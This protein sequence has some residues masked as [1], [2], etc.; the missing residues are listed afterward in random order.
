MEY[1]NNLLPASHSY[2]ATWTC[3]DCTGHVEFLFRH[4]SIDIS[5]VPISLRPAVFAD[6][7]LNNKTIRSGESQD[8]NGHIGDL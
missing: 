2:I 4:R 6:G 1:V 5:V 7:S 3:F 8:F